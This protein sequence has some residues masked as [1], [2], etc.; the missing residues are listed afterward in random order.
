MLI[1]I[2]DWLQSDI[3]SY[4]NIQTF[5]LDPVCGEMI[6]RMKL[7]Y[8]KFKKVPG[9]HVPVVQ[10]AGK[11]VRTDVR[12]EPLRKTGCGRVDCLTCQHEDK[13]GGDCQK[14][15]VTYQITCETCL[16]AGNSTSYEGETARNVSLL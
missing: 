9:T 7:E 5:I 14:N 4:A 3:I 10:R 2:R 8:K 1:Q 6:E 11:Y 15:S 12:P 16:L 13:K